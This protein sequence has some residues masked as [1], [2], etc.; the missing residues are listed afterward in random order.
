[1]FLLVLAAARRHAQRY[2]FRPLAIW[3]TRICHHGRG[4]LQSCWACYDE[5]ALGGAAAIARAS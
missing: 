2:N 1:M 3:R 4:A 5:A